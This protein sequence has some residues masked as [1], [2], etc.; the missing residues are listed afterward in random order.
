MKQ[1]LN[2]CDQLHAKSLAMPAIGTGNHNFPDEGVFR[3]FREEFLQYSASQSSSTLKEIRVVVFAKRPATKGLPSPQRGTSSFVQPTHQSMHPGSRVVSFGSVRISLIE[4]DITQHPTNAIINLLPSDLKLSN[5]GGVCQS[6][7]RNGGQAIQQQ[8]NSA[9]RHS[10]GSVVPT[11]SGSLRNATWIIHF[12]PTSTDAPSLQSSMEACLSQ[13]MLQSL[14]SVSVGAIG[15]ESFGLSPRSSAEVVLNAAKKFS[16]LNYPL[17][18]DIV[19]FQKSMVQ[20]FETVMQE[21]ATTSVA[22]VHAATVSQASLPY[23]SSQAQSGGTS[24]LQSSTIGRFKPLNVGG[25]NKAVSLHI[26]AHSKQD[27]DAS[28]DEV[29]KFVKDNSKMKEIDHEKVFNVLLQFWSNVEKLARNHNV[30]ITC[31]TP[32]VACIEGLVTNVSDCAE[33]LLRLKNKYVDEERKKHERE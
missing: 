27:I 23:S 4:G 21:R 31:Q 13:S 16:T 6:I 7:L 24:N 15:T 8:L 30:R 3:I 32:S 12:V 11:T 10:P 18:E 1:I 33:E 26:F 25:A 28:L 29:R 9:G 17:N 19:V 22:P 5:G 20:D 14:G 2:E